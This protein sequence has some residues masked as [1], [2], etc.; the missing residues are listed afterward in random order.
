MREN[1][2]QNNSKYGLILRSESIDVILTSVFSKNIG[3]DAFNL[4]EKSFSFISKSWPVQKEVI[5][6][7][8]IKTTNRNRM[9]CA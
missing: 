1:S 8:R 7:F 6:Y 2:D 4:K 5:Q 3:D 9:K